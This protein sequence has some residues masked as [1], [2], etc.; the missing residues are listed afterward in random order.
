MGFAVQISRK[1]NQNQIKIKIKIKIKYQK[2]AKDTRSRLVLGR[3]AAV[4]MYFLFFF[5]FL[6]LV[7]FFAYMNMA[8]D[9]AAGVCKKD[10]LVR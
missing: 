1:L 4:G 9:V 3:W 10:I 5:V 8:C 7:G 2:G 6:F